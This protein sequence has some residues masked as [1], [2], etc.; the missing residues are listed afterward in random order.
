M[1][2]ANHR[3]NQLNVKWLLFGCMCVCLIVCMYMY[4]CMLVRHCSGSLHIFVCARVFCVRTE[5][6]PSFIY[7]IYDTSWYMHAKHAIIHMCAC[8]RPVSKEPH[9]CI[10]THMAIVWL[11]QAAWRG[12]RCSRADAVCNI[13]HWRQPQKRAPTQDPS[14]RTAW[15]PGNHSAKRSATHT[16]LF[17]WFRRCCKSFCKVSMHVTLPR[18]DPEDQACSYIHACTGMRR[19][20]MLL[21]AP[22]SWLWHFFVFMG[23]PPSPWTARKRWSFSWLHLLAPDS[24]TA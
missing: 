10:C 23:S 17:R 20:P 9:A 7:S 14:G 18:W 12:T 3:R 5:W 21:S 15:H 8:A 13:W 24:C 11:T 16:Q 6:M 1:Q 4:A 19:G 22:L 2:D